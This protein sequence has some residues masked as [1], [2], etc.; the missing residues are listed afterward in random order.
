MGTDED[1][2]RRTDSR[3][4]GFSPATCTGL[5]AGAKQVEGWAF[6]RKEKETV[7][8]AR[9][10]QRCTAGFQPGKG[11]VTIGKG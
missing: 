11:G 1:W 5:G 4:M 2:I 8:R 6:E 10:Q 9:Q 3:A 7:A